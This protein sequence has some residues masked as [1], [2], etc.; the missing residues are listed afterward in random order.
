MKLIDVKIIGYCILLVGL[1]CVSLP[2]SPSGGTFK[3]MAIRQ[4]QDMPQQETYSRAD[5]FS[6]M[7]KVAGYSWRIASAPPVGGGVAML[8]GAILIDVG[9]RQKRLRS[10]QG[11]T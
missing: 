4:W 6:A 5:L 2:T 1:A 9:S 11:N 3:A 8:V 7:E 10:N